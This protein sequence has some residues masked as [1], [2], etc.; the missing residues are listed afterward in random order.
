MSRSI[1]NI[2]LLESNVNK[3]NSLIIKLKSEN[4]KI[5]NELNLKDE[6]LIEKSDELKEWKDKYQSLKIAN[7]FLGSKD[8][9]LTKLKINNLVKDLDKCISNLSS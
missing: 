6:S 8:K 9:S 3:L 5:I 1:D 4:L 7:T 2:V